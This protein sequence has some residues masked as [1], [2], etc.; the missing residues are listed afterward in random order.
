[1][2]R[3]CLRFSTTMTTEVY[4]VRQPKSSLAYLVSKPLKLCLNKVAV[5]IFG[6]SVTLLTDKVYQ[7]FSGSRALVNSHLILYTVLKQGGVW[8]QLQVAGRQGLP[9]LFGLT[10]LGKLASKPLNGTRTRWCMDATA[11]QHDFLST[12]CLIVKRKDFTI[13]CSFSNKIFYCI[14]S[15][16]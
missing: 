1:M 4:C 2:R 11:S 9:S 16:V 12:V 7:V 15:F 3:Y 14:K 6:W 5:A 13:G 8:M 10:S